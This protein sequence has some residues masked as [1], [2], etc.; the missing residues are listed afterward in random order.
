MMIPTVHHN[1]TSKAEL[2]SLYVSACTACA[3]AITALIAA[4]PNGR[5][6]YVQGPDAFGKAQKEHQ[7]RINKVH[8]VRC[9]LDALIIA[10]DQQD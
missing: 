5:D 6:Y 1:G 9:E 8:A 7:E 3:D 10:V 2:M 4:S